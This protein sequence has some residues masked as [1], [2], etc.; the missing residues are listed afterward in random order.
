MIAAI[1]RRWTIAAVSDRH[2]ERAIPPFDHTAAEMPPAAASRG[3]FKNRAHIR[4]TP[5]IGTQ[6]GNSKCRPSTTT[7]EFSIGQKDLTRLREI[8]RDRHVQKPALPVRRDRRYTRDASRSPVCNP[9]QISVPFRYQKRS[10]WQKPDRPRRVQTGDH[11]GDAHRPCGGVHPM[12]NTPHTSKNQ[13]RHHPKHA[14]L[15]PSIGVTQS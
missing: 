5:P 4:Q 12:K 1:L 2:I 13:Y 8:A 15:E 7:L 11:R 9:Q 6:F 10:I 3:R 14:H